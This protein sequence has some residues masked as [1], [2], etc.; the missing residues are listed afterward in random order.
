MRPPHLLALALALFG[1]TSRAV[2]CEASAY[3]G[4]G[5]PG[6]CTGEHLN[7]ANQTRPGT[8]GCFE[9]VNGACGIVAAQDGAC[10]CAIRF[11]AGGDCNRTSV[12]QLACHDVGAVTHV[13]FDHFD[14]QC[15]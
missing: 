4:A 2:Y 10:N 11:F 3:L 7:R 13:D 14:I 9:A 5:Q 12:A 15:I 8:S 6:R 1:T